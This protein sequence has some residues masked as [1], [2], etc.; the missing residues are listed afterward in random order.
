MTAMR[1]AIASFECP[2]PRRVELAANRCGSEQWLPHRRG[3]D[4]RR[5]AFH[6]RFAPDQADVWRILPATGFV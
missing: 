2:S 4:L 1:D 6:H 5:S 3:I